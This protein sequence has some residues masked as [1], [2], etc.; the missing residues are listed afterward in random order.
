LKAQLPS[1]F[2]AM[3]CLHSQYF[4]DGIIITS[5]A[6]LRLTYTNHTKIFF[7]C[8]PPNVWSSLLCSTRGASASQLTN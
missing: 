4:E 1:V 5:T 3:Q 7:Q 2:S 8:Q 6:L